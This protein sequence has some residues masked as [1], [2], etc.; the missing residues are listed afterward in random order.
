MLDFDLPFVRDATLRESLKRDLG[1]I[2]VNWDNKRWKPVIVASGSVMEAFLVD[3]LLLKGVTAS[4]GLKPKPIDESMLGDLI[5]E[6]ERQKLVNGDIKNVATA[7]KN[8]RNLIHPGRELRLK[9]SPDEATALIATGLLH[10]IVEEV[11][12]ALT[13][14]RRL[15][16]QEL[17][18]KVQ[19]TPNGV[20]ILEALLD[21]M[22]EIDRLVFAKD[23]VPTA[24]L[25]GETE[26]ISRAGGPFS[27]HILEGAELH[28]MRLK[29]A[30]QAAYIHLYFRCF[31]SLQDANKQ[32]CLTA[33]ADRVRR[34][35]ER[36]VRILIQNLFRAEHLLV[37]HEEDRRILASAATHEQANGDQSKYWSAYRNLLPYLKTPDV[38]SIAVGAC[39]CAFTSGPFSGW[40]AAKDFLR[41]AFRSGDGN[42]KAALLQVAKTED[43]QQIEAFMRKKTTSSALSTPDSIAAYISA[44]EV[45]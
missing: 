32:T 16:A 40:S 17:M 3:A 33:L 10:S 8:Y 21:P 30:R 26:F 34:S 23:L 27:A 41:H 4:T 44:T 19:S 13:D 18:A 14:P 45:S 15:T 5:E 35:G 22:W 2:R 36:H 24:L 1:D 29:E 39:R 11:R 12:K 42:L 37:A 7:I 31:E 38:L 28:E 9:I 6:A 20:A 43:D 25:D